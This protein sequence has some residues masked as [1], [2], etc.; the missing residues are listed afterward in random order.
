MKQ[1]KAHNIAQGLTL[2][3]ARRQLAAEIA[4]AG[5]SKN[6]FDLARAA[7]LAA[8]D[9]IEAVLAHENSRKD[10]Y[11]ATARK[12][13]IAIITEKVP[14]DEARQLTFTPLAVTHEQYAGERTF[15]EYFK[16]AYKSLSTGD[17]VLEYSDHVESC[18]GA[19]ADDKWSA[20]AIDAFTLDELVAVAGAIERGQYFIEDFEGDPKDY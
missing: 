7:E 20:D 11:V 17:F 6:H 5:A 18:D 3:T 8:R 12:G 14:K 1:K 10:A 2:A 15:V 13:L 9:T 4:L 19:P 16:R